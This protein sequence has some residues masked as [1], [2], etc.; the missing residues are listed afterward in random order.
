MAGDF[1][2]IAPASV[3]RASAVLLLS[4][5]NRQDSPVPIVSLAQSALICASIRLKSAAKSFQSL[6][7][8]ENFDAPEKNTATARIKQIR[9]KTMLPCT[10]RAAPTNPRAAPISMSDTAPVFS[11]IVPSQ[12]AMHFAMEALPR[13]GKCFLTLRRFDKAAGA[14]RALCFYFT[15]FVASSVYG[16]GFRSRF[17]ATSPRESARSSADCTCSQLRASEFNKFSATFLL[18]SVSK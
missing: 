13:W 11:R 5:R 10:P 4:S 9:A 15:L 3:H 8:K 18:T 17:L 7:D 1:R 12:D 6:A 14:T 2:S 16:S